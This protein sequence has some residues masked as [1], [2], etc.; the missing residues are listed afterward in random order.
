MILKRSHLAREFAQS[1]ASAVSSAGFR[2]AFAELRGGTTR[3]NSY[4]PVGGLMREHLSAFLEKK[5]LDVPSED[6]RFDWEGAQRKSGTQ[7]HSYPLLGTWAHPDAAVLRPFTCAIEWDTEAKPLESR[8]KQRLMKAAVHSLSGAYDATLFI[9]LLTPGSKGRGYVEDGEPTS[10]R[11]L[12]H[13]AVHG[14][15]TAFVRS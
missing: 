2:A 14:V 7:V 8:F 1:L 10:S 11:L 5:Q 15:I 12:A 4:A 3:Y 9:Y 6:V 13:L